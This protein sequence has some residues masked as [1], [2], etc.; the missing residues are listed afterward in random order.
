MQGDRFRLSRP[1]AYAIRKKYPTAV[2]IVVGM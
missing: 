2:Q 1:V